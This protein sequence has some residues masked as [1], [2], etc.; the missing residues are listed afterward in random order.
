MC[1]WAFD[2]A[3]VRNLF[4]FFQCIDPIDV[5]LITAGVFLLVAPVGYKGRNQANTFIIYKEFRL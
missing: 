1:D 5:I 4:R 2:K 3:I